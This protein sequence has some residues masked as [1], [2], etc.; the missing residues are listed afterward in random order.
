MELPD[1][2]PPAFTIPKEAYPVLIAVATLYAD[3]LAFMNELGFCFV[4]QIPIDLIS[5]NLTS[6]LVLPSLGLV[7]AIIGFFVLPLF[8]EKSAAEG[9]FALAVFGIGA[10]IL[11]VLSQRM[12]ILALLIYF[13]CWASVGYLLRVL[14]PSFHLSPK[15]RRNGYYRNIAA[16]MALSIPFT[17]GYSS[18]TATAWPRYAFRQDN[19]AY[20]VLR[21]YNDN[22]VAAPYRLLPSEP[23]HFWG[24]IRKRT[25]IA[26]D[27]SLRIL[28]AGPGANLGWER[29]PPGTVIQPKL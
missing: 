4:Y 25:P 3:I 23:Q 24:L 2:T 19:T 13:G 9:I 27:G 18:W 15:E 8:T 7:A 11:I 1:S 29:L 14:A 20:L 6:L 26:L 5:L 21:V 12:E 16:A 17:F 28:R 22:V 10:T